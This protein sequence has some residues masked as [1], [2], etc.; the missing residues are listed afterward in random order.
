VC[1]CVCVCVC[2]GGF[3]CPGESREDARVLRLLS[4][5]LL[6]MSVCAEAKQ[7]TGKHTSHTLL[8][9]VDLKRSRSGDAGLI[10][11]EGKKQITV[12]D[13]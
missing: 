1:V 12:E 11:A 7:N 9:H 6:H 10:F 8:P 2:K 13:N 3:R 5:S 4:L